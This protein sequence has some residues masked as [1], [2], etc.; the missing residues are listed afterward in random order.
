MGKQSRGG[1]LADLHQDIAEVPFSC[2]LQRSGQVQENRGV[3]SCPPQTSHVLDH[4]NEKVTGDQV[5]SLDSQAESL[6]FTHKE[7]LRTS[8]QQ[9]LMKEVSEDEKSD[10]M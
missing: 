5:A 3:I 1:R 9:N 2:W 7:T 6:D 8:K 4:S 10:I